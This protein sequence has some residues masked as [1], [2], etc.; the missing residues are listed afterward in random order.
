[1]KARG[2]YSINYLYYMII[3]Y[4]RKDSYPRFGGKLRNNAQ[5]EQLL[6]IIGLEWGVSIF[7]AY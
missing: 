2:E 5:I 1:M 3:V 7:I 6:Y 4:T